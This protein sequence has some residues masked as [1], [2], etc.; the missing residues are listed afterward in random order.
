MATPFQDQ[1]EVFDNSFPDREYEIEIT[2]PEFTSI[3]P[4]TGQP[5]FGTLIF[6]YV[7]GAKCVELKSLKLYL[8]KFRNEGIFYENVTNR[9]LD[10][11]VEMLKP[12]RLTLESHWG[13]RGGIS[14]VITI[15]YEENS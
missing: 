10:D 11:F 1:L 8:Q 12:R 13:P 5:D 9:I 2:C 14:S 3:C 4:M 15:D 6:R 7:P